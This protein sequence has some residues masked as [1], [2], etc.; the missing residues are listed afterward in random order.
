MEIK[1]RVLETYHV[2]HQIPELG[3]HEVQTSAYLAEKLKSFGYD[4]TTGLGRGTGIVG[5][6]KGKEA[7]PTV[8]LRADMDALGFIID[9]KPVN[10]HACGHDAHSS[11][12]LAAAEALSKRGIKR[13]TLQI[14]FQPAEEVFGAIDMIKQGIGKDLDMLFGI[15]LR[16]IQE[17]KL[18]QMTPA[19]YHGASWTI[20]A[21]IK[22]QVAHA[23]RPHLGVN[24]I[25]AACS[26]IQAVNSIAT[27]PVVASSV[28]ATQIKGGGPASNSIPESASITF[29][30]RS[31]T[32]EV[33][34]DIL[35]KVKVAIE[36]AAVAVGASAE[37]EIVGG[38]PAAS[39]NDEMIA[40]ARE[41]IVD[42]LGEEAV[43]EKIVTP[44]AEDFHYFTREYPHLK[45]A[46]MGL[47]CDLTPGLH[48]A[49]MNFNKD[50]LEK[51]SE[52]LVK[53]IEKALAR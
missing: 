45:A 13:G 38:V 22:G 30:V 23:A 2:L 7:G 8:G 47:G 34:D 40:L 20:K 10:I 14:I 52:V 11:M 21:N 43:I 44:G 1:E 25:N 51:G 35:A 46:Y 37:M 48:A 41:S 6:L 32:N 9:D 5:V 31:S 15:H 3:H 27:N 53:T 18:G 4:V 17:A 50:A 26:I 12:V 19:L 49:T 39:Y 24:A 33:A 16:P 36:S 42:V 28:K 29:D